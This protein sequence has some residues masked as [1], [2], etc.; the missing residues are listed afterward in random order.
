LWS[1]LGARG[2]D[3]IAWEAFSEQWVIDIVEQLQLEKVRATVADHGQ[4]VDLT[5]S[6]DNDVVFAW[7]GTAP[8][9][10]PA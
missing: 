9:E 6:D 4:I 5:K 10:M 1:L 3:V 7:N 2:V 8:C